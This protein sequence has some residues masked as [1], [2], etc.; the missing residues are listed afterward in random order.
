MKNLSQSNKRPIPEYV[1]PPQIQISH[2]VETILV[3]KWT[4]GFYFLV[5]IGLTV[6]VSCAF[7][8]DKHLTD[9]RI[10]RCMSQKSNVVMVYGKARTC[11]QM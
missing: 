7:M 4:R 11:P 5:V 1:P 6:F 10:E 3:D 2:P 9:L 8:F